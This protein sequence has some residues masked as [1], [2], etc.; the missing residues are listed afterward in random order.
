MSKLCPAAYLT[1][2][3]PSKSENFNYQ[4]S[5]LKHC[6][7][8]PSFPSLFTTQHTL[9]HQQKLLTSCCAE[10]PTIIRQLPMPSSRK[11][12]L[13]YLTPLHMMKNILSMT[14]TPCR[15]A[16]ET[17]SEL[18]VATGCQGLRL[19]VMLDPLVGADYYNLLSEQN[20]DKLNFWNPHHGI[21]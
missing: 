13:S 1:I 10:N 21:R 3:P 17:P 4:V 19:R 9:A 14:Y 8:L 11:S 5:S 2:T 12:T 16:L 6:T 15:G 18:P 20:I 7:I